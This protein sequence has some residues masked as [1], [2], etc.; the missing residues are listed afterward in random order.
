[1]FPFYGKYF[2]ARMVSLTLYENIN[3]WIKFFLYKDRNELPI[4]TKQEAG[5]HKTYHKLLIG[6]HNWSS[7]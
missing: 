7:Q 3:G 5:P 1:M 4:W 6:E 2:S